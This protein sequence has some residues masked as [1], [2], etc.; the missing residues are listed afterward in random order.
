MKSDFANYG[1]WVDISA[2]GERILSTYPVSR[3]AYWSGTSMATP[4]VAGQAALII[5]K[6]ADDTPD[7]G[8]VEEKV[9]RSA[10]YDDFYAKNSSYR[11]LCKLGAGHT[12]IGVSVGAKPDEELGLCGI[13]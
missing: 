11:V 3:Y 5:Q 13:P 2:P 6:N 4:F 10:R 12:D 9:R 8:D 7:P 1:T